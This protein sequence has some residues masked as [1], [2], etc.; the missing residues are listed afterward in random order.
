MQLLSRLR[1]EVG[2]EQDPS[3]SLIQAYFSNMNQGI[4]LRQDSMPNERQRRMHLNSGN[5]IKH[6]PW[7]DRDFLGN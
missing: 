1:W 7:V 2:R 6:L 5:K 3:P 4:Q